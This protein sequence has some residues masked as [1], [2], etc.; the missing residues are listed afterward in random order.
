[1][2]TTDADVDGSPG[3]ANDAHVDAGFVIPMTDADVDGSA[4]GGQLGA[5]RYLPL[6]GTLYDT[7]TKLTWQQTPAPGTYTWSGAKSYCSSLPVNGV[8]WRLP[9]LK[10]LVTIVDFAAANP[11]IDH[12]FS[13]TPAEA[14]WSSTPFASSFGYAWYVDFR[15][16]DSSSLA[17][18]T[19]Q[20]VRC[21]R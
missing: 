21:A 5:S 8:A 19:R 11:A 4:E 10:E 3:N 1:M 14:F 17:V 2:P 9:T 13:N 7:K 18:S 16:G 12:A 15:F 6:D 20:D